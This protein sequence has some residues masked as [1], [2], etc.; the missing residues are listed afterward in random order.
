MSIVDA[1]RQMADEVPVEHVPFEVVFRDEYRRIARVIA[2]ILDNPARA[3]ELAVEVFCKLL[4]NPTAALSVR[5][6]SIQPMTIRVADLTA[7]LK[8]PSHSE[9]TEDQTRLQKMNL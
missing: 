5:E 7:G 2:R 9:G 4:R 3:E 8:T 6:G 1:E